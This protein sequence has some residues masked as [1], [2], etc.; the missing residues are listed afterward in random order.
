MKHQNRYSC[1]LIGRGQEGAEPGLSRYFMVNSLV[2]TRPCSQGLL[3]LLHH[4]AS[5]MGENLL[6]FSQRLKT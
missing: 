6:M 2:T 3:Q 5:P 1:C 4:F